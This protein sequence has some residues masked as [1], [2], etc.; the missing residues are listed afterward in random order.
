METAYLSQANLGGK[1][2]VKIWVINYDIKLL[3]ILVE[4]A[5]VLINDEWMMAGHFGYVIKASL[6][7]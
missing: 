7:G 2:G 6:Y 4:W 3:Y 1:L 5:T